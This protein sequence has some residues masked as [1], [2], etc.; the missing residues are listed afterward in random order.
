MSWLLL[1][2]AGIAYEF[3]VPDPETGN[4]V[5]GLPASVTFNAVSSV[6]ALAPPEPTSAAVPWTLR[7][8]DSQSVLVRVT[9][10]SFVGQLE[11]DYQPAF[12]SYFNGTSPAEVVN[13][14]AGSG[15]EVGEFIPGQFEVVAYTDSTKNQPP[16]LSYGSSAYFDGVDEVPLDGRWSFRLEVWVDAPE[17]P[18]EKIDVDANERTYTASQAA[19]TALTTWIRGLN[20]RVNLSAIPIEVVVAPYPKG[21]ERLTV[22]AAGDA[23]GQ[24]QWGITAEQSKKLGQGLYRIIIRRSDKGELLHRGTLEIAA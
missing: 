11:P 24:V 5:P 17:P 2:S 20:G 12:F 22:S 10:S 23:Q 21:H 14:A 13:E 15:D 19:D 6:L 9:A 3:L 16:R 1:G 4:E 7:F 18:I 8:N